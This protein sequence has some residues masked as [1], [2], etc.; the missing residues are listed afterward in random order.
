M[1]GQSCRSA[2]FF[3]SLLSWV[4][5]PVVAQPSFDCSKAESR[6]ELCLCDPEKAELQALD[7]QLAEH[8]RALR[9]G[10]SPGQRQWLLESQRRWLERRP[11]CS[12]SG[13]DSLERAYRQ[14]VAELGLGVVTT[15]LRENEFPYQFVLPNGAE[16]QLDV[17]GSRWVEGARAE[18]EPLQTL[19]L[20]S[21][22]ESSDNEQ[23]LWASSGEGVYGEAPYERRTFDGVDIVSLPDERMVLRVREHVGGLFETGDD[24]GG[25][26]QLYLALND[27]GQFVPQGLLQEWY[28]NGDS[29]SFTA[30]W[31]AGE[32]GPLLQVDNKYYDSWDLSRYLNRRERRT[33]YR[34]RFDGKPW[35]Q[36]QTAE[37]QWLLA[38]DAGARYRELY[39]KVA[40]EVIHDS[41]PQVPCI[42]AGINWSKA[43]DGVRQ[44]LDILLAG[45]ARGIPYADAERIIARVMEDEER[46]VLSEEILEMFRALNYLRGQIEA[47][48]DWQ[49]RFDAI[50]AA[51]AEAD[52][53]AGRPIGSQLDENVLS[54]YGFPPL[55][56]ECLTSDYLPDYWGV[57]PD[58]WFYNFWLR[59]YLEGNYEL[60]QWVV[61]YALHQ[62]E[63]SVQ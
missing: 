51:N 16:V 58:A 12:H 49:T 48:D 19:Y 28:G 33:L 7:R 11:E 24:K 59:R 37:E 54:E 30:K 36:L 27:S 10:M 13:S 40:A 5:T 29:E 3:L 60:T 26:A 46:V 34:M 17:E 4:C 35:E 43:T 21:D 57:A 42:E 61:S 23:L 8:Y 41:A 45:Q 6:V 52:R 18:D 62:G 25:S 39:R 31:V 55:G 53:N 38:D 47:T 32:G 2:L 63:S 1:S 14:R 44:S 15:S 50:Y 56:G 22:Y 20:S 9:E